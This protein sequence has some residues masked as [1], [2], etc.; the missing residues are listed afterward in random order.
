MS[1][2]R[3]GPMTATYIYMSYRG[4]IIE[5]PEDTK[6][7]TGGEAVDPPETYW[8]TTHVFETASEKYGWLNRIVAVGVGRGSSNGVEYNVYCIL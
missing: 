4:F 1:G 2:S 7:P 3:F 6:H 8:R 5:P